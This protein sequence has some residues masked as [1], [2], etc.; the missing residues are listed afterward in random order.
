MKI[1]TCG[2]A[3][4]E[5]ISGSNIFTLSGILP[6][7][8]KDSDSE[9]IIIQ[10]GDSEFEVNTQ[11]VTS[12]KLYA[13]MIPIIL[14]FTNDSM[15]EDTGETKTV[16]DILTFKFDENDGK[17][18]IYAIPDN[19]KIINIEIF[20][21]SRL[22]DGMEFHHI[23]DYGVGH[24]NV[25]IDG[26]TTPDNF[27]RDCAKRYRS[28]NTF[29]WYLTLV[30]GSMKSPIAFGCSD[31]NN[32]HFNVLQAIYDRFDSVYAETVKI[33]I[34]NQKCD[35]KIMIGIVPINFKNSYESLKYYAYID[36]GNREKFDVE[37]C[38]ELNIIMRNISKILSFMEV[39]KSIRDLLENWDSTILFTKKMRRIDMNSQYGLLSADRSKLELNEYKPEKSEI[40]KNKFDKMFEY[41]DMKAGITD[42]PDPI[43]PM[44]IP[45]N[46]IRS[47]VSRI[48]NNNT[49]TEDQND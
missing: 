39:D 47:I 36:H 18:K 26:E 20:W 49:E 21:F 38:D 2:F 11:A 17:N 1:D 12:C 32:I 48:M 30:S 8:E 46:E 22:H 14:V 23:L 3:Y 42:V 13:D 27:R 35:D 16:H 15:I 37:I 29:P 5:R 4:L 9:P 41:A 45:D 31:V 43:S 33:E 44:T 25:R 10:K 28:H 24:V 6:I 7:F 40:V 34:V 19:K